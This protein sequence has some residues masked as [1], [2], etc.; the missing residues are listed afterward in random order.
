MVFTSGTTARRKAVMLT[1]GNFARGNRELSRLRPRGQQRRAIAS[2]ASHT[3]EFTCGMLLPLASGANDCLSARIDAK[4]LSITL[5]DL[6]P[7]ALIGVP[8]GWD[9]CIGAYSMSRRRAWAVLCS[10]RGHNLRD[11]TAGSTANSGTQMSFRNRISPGSFRRSARGR[12]RLAVS[13]VV[14]RPPHRVADFCNDI[15]IPP[16]LEVTGPYPKL[17]ACCGGAA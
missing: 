2:A 7:T 12:L 9:A 14:L 5:A 16:L 15:G 3:F 11:P 4:T 13:G 17:D 1:H 10:T 8:A 6:R